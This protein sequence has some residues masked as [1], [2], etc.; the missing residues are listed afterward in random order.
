M[1]VRNVPMP[2]LNNIRLHPVQLLMHMHLQPRLGF[3][4]ARLR[5]LRRWG[6]G[7]DD[8]EDQQHHRQHRRIGQ[9]GEDSA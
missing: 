2:V 5:C 8:L 1:M 7:K 4:R 9:P 6:G 3:R